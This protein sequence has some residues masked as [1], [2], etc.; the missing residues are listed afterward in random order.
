[1]PYLSR[2]DIDRFAERIIRLYKETKADSQISYF[3]V[4]LYKPI[5][6]GFGHFFA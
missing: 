4:S 3:Y 1:M 6:L 5:H 2:E